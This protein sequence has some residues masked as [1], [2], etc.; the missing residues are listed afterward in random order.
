MP[1]IE[2]EVLLEG[3]YSIEKGYEVTARNLDVLFAE[4]EKANV[5]IHLLSF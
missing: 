1:I 3:D 2:P 4:L 5:F